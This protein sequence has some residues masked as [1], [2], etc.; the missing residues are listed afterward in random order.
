[1]ST[2]TH[3]HNTHLTRGYLIALASAAVLSTTAVFIRVLTQT[4]H[5]PALILALWRDGIVAATLIIVLLF[6]QPKL[7]H[8]SRKMLLF[9]ILYGFFQAI[10]NTFWTL[11]VA[12][13]GA[14]ISTVLVYS[15]AAF[16]ALLGWWILKENL[17]WSKILAVIFSITGCVLVAGALDPSVW[18]ANLMGFIVGLIS[19]LS[20]AI[21]SLMGRSASQQGLKPWTTVLY[22]FG[23][24]AVFL[25]FFNFLPWKIL[26]G[27]VQQPADLLLPGVGWQ[28]W[29]ILLLL[30]IGPTLIGF[31]LY[32]T[33]LVYL[34]SSV[35]NLIATLEP[36]FTAV[37]A[38]FF[39]GEQ[40]TIEEVVGS[41][42]IMAGVV[43]L[44]IFEGR[45]GSKNEPSE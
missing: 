31:I 17:S 37:T 9:L 11:S 19:G 42:L 23:I 40:L 2:L 13:N 24:A 38:Y 1:M 8:V 35:A 5:L 14:A 26:P 32:N 29:G 22:T 21:Y 27:M 33:S 44:R 36:A 12:M 4:Y 41:L 34:P 15:S 7:L 45:S 25:L 20:Y 6:W 30:A 16:T 43:F 10:F 28:G 3:T 18:K 39:L